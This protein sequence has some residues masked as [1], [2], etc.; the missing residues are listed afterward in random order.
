VQ[1][2][3]RIQIGELPGMGRM[4]RPGQGGAGMGRG[5]FGGGFGGG[6]GRGGGGGFNPGGGFGNFG[7]T[8]PEEEWDEVAPSVRRFPR[9]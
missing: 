3:K 4:P 8:D 7:R 6:A 9:V 5:G 2:A 1:Y